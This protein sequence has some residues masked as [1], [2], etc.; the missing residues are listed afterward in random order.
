MGLSVAT[1]VG[2]SG[3]GGVKEIV[4]QTAVKEKEAGNDQE[5]QLRVQTSSRKR[6]FTKIVF[7]FVRLHSQGVCV[8]PS[9]FTRG[10]CCQRGHSRRRQQDRQQ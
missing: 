6:E 5:M 4:V 7:S 8:V 9:S 2:G 10:Q 3:R 1:R